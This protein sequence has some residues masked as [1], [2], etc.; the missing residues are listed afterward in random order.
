[1]QPS[2]RPRG[3]VTP[4][5]RQ[6]S[7][8]GLVSYQP[9]LSQQQA[10][11]HAHLGN[12]HG[13]LGGAKRGGRV[14]G[15]GGPHGSSGGLGAGHPELDALRQQVGGAGKGGR[16]GLGSRGW[17]E[18]PLMAILRAVRRGLSALPAAARPAARRVGAGPVDGESGA[19]GCC[20]EPC[21]AGQGASWASCLLPTPLPAAHNAHP[22]GWRV[23]PHAASRRL[24]PPRSAGSTCRRSPAPPWP[25][26][27]ARG[28]GKQACA[29]SGAQRACRGAGRC[30]SLVQRAGMWP[31]AAVRGT[32]S[33]TAVCCV[34]SRL[35]REALLPPLG[36]R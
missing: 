26:R 32:G 29:G 17:A 30:M 3:S 16:R 36:K 9:L 19:A 28:E 15:G 33:T 14:V 10:H 5:S 4:L 12:G 6:V 31:L 35:Y 22:E 25:P 23:P 27:P 13:G 24:T 34:P 18:A 1:M 20:R 7:Y 2:G 11:T 21:T 8:Q